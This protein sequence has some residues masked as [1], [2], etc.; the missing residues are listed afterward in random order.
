MCAW[1]CVCV[2]EGEERWRGGKWKEWRERGRERTRV[3][4]LVWDRALCCLRLPTS[5]RGFSCFQSFPIIPWVIDRSWYHTWINK[6]SQDST[7]V[8][9][10]K[11]QKSQLLCP[12]FISKHLKI[13]VKPIYAGYIM[14]RVWRAE[15]ELFLSCGSLRIQPGGQQVSWSGEPLLRFSYKVLL[16]SP[17]WP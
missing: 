4:C 2:R 1:E 17:G 16:C 5:F 13:T 6:G 8:F 10:K 12:C 7:Q 14:A 11:T 3:S 9:T 15:D